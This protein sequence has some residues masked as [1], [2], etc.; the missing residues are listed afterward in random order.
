MRAR[1]LVVEDNPT[2]L[3]LMEYLLRTFGYDVFTASDGAEGIEVARRE[4]PDVILMDLQMPKLNGFDAVRQLKAN[5]V[6]CNIPVVAVTALAMVGDRDKILAHKF[7]GYIAKPIAPETFVDEVQAFI[8]PALHPARAFAQPPQASTEDSHA[9][10]PALPSGVARILVV[11]NSQVNLAVVQSTLKPSGY[12]VLTAHSVDE[13]LKIAQKQ[14]PDLFL[15]DVH[16]PGQGGFDLLRLVKS[17]ERLRS[18]PFVF[19]SSTV[20]GERDRATALAMG[21][22]RFIARPIEPAALLAEV[23]V[24]LKGASPDAGAT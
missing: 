3:A 11:D 12:D 2:N 5:P 1:V 14:M 21:A 23:E 24:C 4:S 22:Q 20:W 6:L 7:N 17:D 15:C 18:V 9:A 13:A 16:M 8:P 10:L 19:L